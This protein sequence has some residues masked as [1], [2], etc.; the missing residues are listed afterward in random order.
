MNRSFFSRAN[1]EVPEVKDN[2][3]VQTPRSNLWETVKS[4]RF[5]GLFGGANDEEEKKGDENRLESGPS[6]FEA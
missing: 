4:F 1:T 5:T 6:R 2:Q 3:N